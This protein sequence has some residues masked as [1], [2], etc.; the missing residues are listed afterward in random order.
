MCFVTIGLPSPS[1]ADTI[2]YFAKSM[3]SQQ[4]IKF[5]EEQN[6]GKARHRSNIKGAFLLDRN[7]RN[8]KPHA[9]LLLINCRDVRSRAALD[10]WKAPSSNGSAHQTR[11]SNQKLWQRTVFP[12]SSLLLF[13]GQPALRGHATL[14]PSGHMIC[15]SHHRRL[16]E[17][18]QSRSGTRTALKIN[19][20]TAQVNSLT[21]DT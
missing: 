4:F 2:S 7:A 14:A 17:A 3:C 21:N 6:R 20:D 5:Q 13:K 11:V 10:A 16:A 12:A 19:S 18:V 1:E 8:H 15:Q 9:T